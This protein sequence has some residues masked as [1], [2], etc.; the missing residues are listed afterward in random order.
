MFL[1]KYK[2]I[3]AEKIPTRQKEKTERKRIKEENKTERKEIIQEQR[4]ERSGSRWLWVII[5][6]LIVISILLIIKD[7]K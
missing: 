3:D 6:A 2:F 1:T 5:I 4:T 7:R